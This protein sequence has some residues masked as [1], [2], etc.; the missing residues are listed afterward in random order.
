MKYRYGALLA[1]ST[2]DI[3]DKPVTPDY[4]TYEPPRIEPN[5]EYTMAE[6]MA[7]T[8]VIHVADDEDTPTLYVS[9]GVLPYGTSRWRRSTRQGV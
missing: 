6:L 7:L 8:P 3:Q 1:H 2:P 4:G 5:R 9:E